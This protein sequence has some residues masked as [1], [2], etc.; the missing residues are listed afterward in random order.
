MSIFYCLCMDWLNKMGKRHVITDFPIP[1][2]Q[3]KTSCY[4]RFLYSC[5]IMQ[6]VML[7]LIY[8]FPRH[9]ARRHVITDF[10]IPRSQCNTSCYY[11]FLYS[12]VTMQH[13]TLAP[14]SLFL[15]QNARELGF[16]TFCPIFIDFL[17]V[18]ST[19]PIGVCLLLTILLLPKACHCNYIERAIAITTNSNIS[20]ISCIAFIS[21]VKFNC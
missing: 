12:C 16:N 18:V 11:I 4:D 20:Q 1:V 10:S 2:S 14:I 13:V 8:L 3:C 17:W 6:D 5:V 19:S 21:N 9:N 7:L 15:C